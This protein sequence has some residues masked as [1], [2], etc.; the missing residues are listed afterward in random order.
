MSVMPASY[1][2]VTAATTWHTRRVELTEAWL[3]D[4]DKAKRSA[5]SAS[6]AAR[7]RRSTEGQ[8]RKVYG[9]DDYTCLGCNLHDPTGLALTLDHVI[10]ESRGGG[11]SKA[12]LQTLCDPCNQAK[13]D[14]MP[15]SFR[16][17]VPGDRP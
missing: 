6:R 2:P 3:T 7:R 8:R 11:N 10:P 13:A 15:E 9:R 12:N 4:G 16:A 1:R 14:R 5:R 17:Y